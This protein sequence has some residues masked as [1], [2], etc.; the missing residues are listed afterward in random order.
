MRRIMDQGGGRKLIAAL[1]LLDP[2]VPDWQP[3]ACSP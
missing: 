1:M 3:L 2:E